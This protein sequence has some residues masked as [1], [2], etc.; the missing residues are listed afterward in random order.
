M[1]N[2]CLRFLK[3]RIHDNYNPLK[4]VHEIDDEYG[5]DIFRFGAVKIVVM[6]VD[7]GDAR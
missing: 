7:G 5:A 4:L 3:P 6:M 2:G 1:L